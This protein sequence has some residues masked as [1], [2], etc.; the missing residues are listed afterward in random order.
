[1]FSNRPCEPQLVLSNDN[2]MTIGNFV[3]SKN[4]SVKS[5]RF[6]HRNIHKYTWTSRV[7]KTQS[8]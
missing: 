3:T 7:G 4:L 5:T 1:M 8:D 2:G 6:P